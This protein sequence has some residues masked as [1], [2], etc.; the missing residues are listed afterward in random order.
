M[1]K[2]IL[3][4]SAFLVLLLTSCNHWLEL[5]PENEIIKE[6]FWQTQEDVESVLFSAY[7]GLRNL[8]TDLI[9]LGEIR[10]DGV[11]LYSGNASLNSI[12][13]GTLTPDNPY[14]S[15]A[16][17]YQII[18]FCNAVI[19][20]SEKVLERDRNYYQEE[21]DAIVAEAKAMRALSYFY[22]VRLWKEAPLIV[23]S[24][25]TDDQPFV[26]EK[27]T[28]ETILNF[29]TEDLSSCI[30]DMK[31]TYNSEWELYGRLTKLAGLTLLADISLYKEEYS[32][33]IAYCDQVL[34]SP[35]KV[36]E[37]SD[38]WFD[39]LFMGEFTNES[40]FEIAFD[41][42]L[43][44][45]NGVFSLYYNWSSPVFSFAEHW[46][47]G[48]FTSD[49]IRGEQATYDEK[50]LFFLKYVSNLPSKPEFIGSSN[51][52]Y[53]F[54]VYRLAEVYF[55][56]A[57]AHVMLDQY[58]QASQSM[59][60]I[61]D[62]AGLGSSVSV[63]SNKESWIEFLLEEKLREFSG[64]GKRW[65]DLLRIGKKNNW[66]RKEIIIDN[67][68][69][70]V[71]SVDAAKMESMLQ[72]TNAYYLPIHTDEIEYNNLLEQNPYYK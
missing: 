70:F 24:Y 19:N 53:N 29:C 16:K 17:W 56:K 15:W 10:G 45:L 21:H 11:D 55:M 4:C 68:M 60:V 7:A 61:R 64:E 66:E 65:F 54:K 31:N 32:E 35:L 36:L 57:E 20:E 40:I 59:G 34:N 71:K 50:T 8:H 12:R 1:K 72:N 2:I 5:E 25:D 13:N 51:S 47:S 67:L 28:E 58:E 37:N 3:I 63:A 69:E 39:Q 46:K 49:D 62:R 38:D 30:D 43:N 22:I 14:A 44:Q 52:D 9:T 33:A 41:R 18:N 6:D 27:V 48:L 23:E 26:Q 42:Q